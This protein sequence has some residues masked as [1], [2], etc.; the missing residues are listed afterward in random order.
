MVSCT[1]LFQGFINFSSYLKNMMF[2]LTS[3]KLS[4]HFNIKD[5]TNK[6]HKPDL[7]FFSRCP[8][9]TCTDNYKEKTVRHLKESVVD[10]TGRDTKAHI[11]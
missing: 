8:S 2:I 6:Q 9:T 3:T 5:D 4:Y 10:Y 11:V 1:Y 7:F